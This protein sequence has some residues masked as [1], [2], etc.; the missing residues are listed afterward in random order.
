MTPFCL[1]EFTI[2]ELK[3]IGDKLNKEKNS[4]GCGPH[5]C[6]GEITSRKIRKIEYYCK[7]KHGKGSGNT[8]VQE[9]TQF[10]K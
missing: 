5:W 1:R 9:K 4:P 6:L 7:M 2:G 10:G 8:F 3:K